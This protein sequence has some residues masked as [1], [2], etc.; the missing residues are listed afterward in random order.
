ML[1]WPYQE[2]GVGCF[3]ATIL[4]Y[5]APIGLNARGDDPNARRWSI[6]YMGMGCF[7]ATVLLYLA[8]IG[9]NA[10]GDDPNASHW[11]IVLRE[12]T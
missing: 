10:R 12:G 3:T 9:L 6:I 7:A 5:P 11:S 1:E 4:L 8:P 2:Q